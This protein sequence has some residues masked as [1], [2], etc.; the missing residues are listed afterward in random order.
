M[1]FHC[2]P[3]IFLLVYAAFI[4][5]VILDQVEVQWTMET[6]KSCE[7][8][9]FKAQNVPLFVSQ[10]LL[11]MSRVDEKLCS[12]AAVLISMTNKAL[13]LALGVAKMY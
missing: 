11:L 8:C 1:Y 10:F 12:N 5:S 2:S 6:S 3:F 13:G 9:Y 4:L 7:E